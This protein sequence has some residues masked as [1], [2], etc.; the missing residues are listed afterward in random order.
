MVAEGRFRADLLHRIAAWRVRV[1]PL[2]DRP[3]D[4]PLLAVHFLPP[5]VSS[6]SVEAMEELALGDFPGNVR[7]L[8]NSVKTAGARAAAAGSDRILPQHLERE[9]RAQRSSAA[10]GPGSDVEEAVLRARIETALALRE[11]NVAQVARDLGLGRPW[12]YQTLKRFNIDP[13]AY[14]KR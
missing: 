10:P 2:R 5:G 14:R 8:R 7:E 12:L 13:D 9:E 3:E 4:I 11:G 1:P 6:F